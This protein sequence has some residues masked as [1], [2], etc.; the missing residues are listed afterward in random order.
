MNYS[1]EQLQAINDHGQNIL[2]SAGAGSG[3]TAVL[4]ERVI[5]LLKNGCHLN[6]LL[7]LTFTK[8]SA[9]E[10]KERIRQKLLKIP[11]LKKELDKIDEAFITTFDS[12]SLFVV[13]KYHY[14]LNLPQNPLITDSTFLEILKRKCLQEVLEKYYQQEEFQN[15][16]EEFCS[17]DDDTLVKDLLQ[18]INKLSLKN[19]IEDYL[20]NYEPLPFKEVKKDYEKLILQKKAEII[21]TIEE[22]TLVAPK[23]YIT[24]LNTNLNNFYQ[25]NSY[26]ENLAIISFEIPRLPNNSPEEI[27]SQKE[28]LVALTKEFKNLFV[29]ENEL[30]NTYN[31]MQKRK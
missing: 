4:T 9:G 20:N 6:E 2:V 15:F 23:E 24:K 30:E 14:L 3:K 29:Y 22:L 11:S 31:Q 19:D 25:A 27:T 5:T 16:I 12:F 1:Q 8:A 18:M 13:K 28:K 10:M 21:D 26:E 7:I 17:K